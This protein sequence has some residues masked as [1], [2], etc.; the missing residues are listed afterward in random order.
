[1]SPSFFTIQEFL[2]QSS[3]APEASPLTQFFILHRVHNTLLR[4]EGRPEETPDEFYPLAEIILADFAQIDYDRVSAD[5]VYTE[6]RDIALLQQRFPHLSAEQQRFMRQFW[7]S[8]SV[9]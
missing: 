3:V 7:E 1:W 2:R 9:G 6:L 5:E 8:F 4:E